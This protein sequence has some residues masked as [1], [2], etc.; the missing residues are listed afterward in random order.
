MRP[1][2][3]NPTKPH[4]FLTQCTSN[5][6]ASRTNVSEETPYTWRTPGVSVH[7]TQPATEIRRRGSKDLLKIYN[8]SYEGDEGSMKTPVTR[9]ELD[10]RAPGEYKLPWEWKKEQIVKALPG[11]IKILKSSPTLS[12]SLSYMP[13]ISP[14]VCQEYP[15]PLS[16][17]CSNWYHG[18]VTRQ[19]AE[20]QLQSCKETSFLVRN[21]V[22]G[23]SKHSIALRTNQG[24]VHIIIAQ[25]KENGYTLDQSSCVLP[26]IPEGVHLYLTQRLPF[27]EAEHMT[28]LHPLNA[29]TDST[30]YH[31]PVYPDNPMFLYLP[32]IILNEHVQRNAGLQ[33][34]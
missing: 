7:C 3:H 20:S 19:E 30:P 2:K 34:L 27:N 31:T 15:L 14:E 10:P 6:E 16:L 22:S 12:P 29:L 11:T 18:C 9:P 17:G 5:P 1:P 25:T 32:D 8:V 21:S 23:T 26:S 24:C 33:K 28:L 13:N 4:C